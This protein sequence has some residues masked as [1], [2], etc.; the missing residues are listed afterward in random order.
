[1]A[2]ANEDI[3]A[4]LD[5]SPYSPSQSRVDAK[6]DM[7][8]SDA[9][10]DAAPDYRF[11]STTTTGSKHALPARGT[12]DFEPN[13]TARQA[14]S[15]DA[16]RKAMTGA[17]SVTRVHTSRK[18]EN[19]ALYF[20]D[21]TDWDGQ[22]FE[23]EALKKVEDQEKQ[24][25]FKD[26]SALTKGEGRCVAVEKFTSPH[27]RTMGK[28]DRRN[29][30][31]LLPEEALHLL[32]RGSLDIRYE[33]EDDSEEE[34]VEN[35]HESATT[36]HE[37]LGTDT[38]DTAEENSTTR[39]KIGNIPMSLQG[40]YSAF[41]GKSGLT[42]ERYLVYTNLK[43]NGY[44]VQRAP[45]W[46][47]PVSRAEDNYVQTSIAHTQSSPSVPPASTTLI[48][49]LLSWLFTPTIKPSSIPCHNSIVGPLIAPGLFRSYGDIFRQLQIIQQHDLNPE[50][51]ES[52]SAIPDPRLLP[53][54]HVIKPSGIQN[55]RK[56][57]PPSP[58]YIVVVLDARQTEIPSS[59]QIGELLASMP[60]DKLEN[61]ERK[62]LETRIKHGRRSV[63][64]AVVDSGLVSY[65]RFSGGGFAL[66]EGRSLW[67]DSEKRQCERK[68]GKRGGGGRGRGGGRARGRGT[69]G[70]RGI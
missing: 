46:S 29:W 65:L 39:L 20:S 52:S 67:E 38:T 17:L 28:G 12:K 13:P 40:A 58:D 31:W 53:T 15:L 41:I 26:S 51:A 59:T 6:D 35:K 3:V 69:G 44:I 61:A 68:G 21:P 7:S 27:Q 1:M 30:T 16:S 37:A 48:R 18:N 66:G 47:G 8:D 56:S 43:R 5:T 62:K 57:S 10:S 11:L 34:E 36:Q 55:Y 14:S 60:D 23:E 63:L 70:G 54:Y 24:A 49:R 50:P 64:L 22:R 32:E 4:S 9:S 25:R 45:T 42:L 33:D 19:T 2:D